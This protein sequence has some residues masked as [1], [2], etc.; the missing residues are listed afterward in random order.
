[1]SDDRSDYGSVT[2]P[3]TLRLERILP[4]PIERVWTY[5]TDSEKRGTW[6]ASGEMEPRVGGRV[7]HIFRNSEL[8]S[9]D[10]P[11]PPKYAHLGDESRMHGQITALDPPR[12]L[13]YTWSEESDVDSEVTFELSPRGEQVLLV[14]THRRLGTRDTMISVAAGWHTHLGILAARLDDRAP[15][16][17]WA[18]HMR[19]EAEYEKRISTGREAVSPGGR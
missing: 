15:A 13:S 5:L 8:S 14:L 10:D 17:F 9:H 7:E 11:A 3:G 18:T 12:L 6:L 19:L 4:G 16:P 1:M 2:E